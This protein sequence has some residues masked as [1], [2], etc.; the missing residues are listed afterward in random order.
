MAIGATTDNTGVVHRGTAEG[1]SALMASLAGCGG[2][3]VV[4]WLAFGRRTV[5]AVSTARNDTGMVHGASAESRS[6]LMTGFTSRR[7]L[8]M[9]AWFTLG[10]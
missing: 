10:S 5:M 4:T 8:D 9:V 1:T 7:C 3:H 2:L 6:A